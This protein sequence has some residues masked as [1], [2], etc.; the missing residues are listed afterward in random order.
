M[1]WTDIHPHQVF[2]GDLQVFRNLM[3]N[4]LPDSILSVL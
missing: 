1:G 4:V 3:V 2:V